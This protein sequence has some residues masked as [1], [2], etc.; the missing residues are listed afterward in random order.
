MVHYPSPS[1]C[2]QYRLE[3]GSTPNLSRRAGHWIQ[4]A[5][6]FLSWHR[7]FR[8][9]RKP[10]RAQRVVGPRI[11]FLSCT[12][13]A[14]PRRQHRLPVY[15]GTTLRGGSFQTATNWVPQTVPGSNDTAVFDLPNSYSV[16][17]GMAT[18][19][20][21]QIRDGGVIFTNANY[22][23]TAGGPQSAVRSC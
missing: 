19:E 23:A 8:V 6:Y 10:P 13:L 15:T 2:K 12:Q 9:C 17:V 18:T 7:V 11:S 14:P 3:A 20:Q 16:D 22:H 1:T 4:E 21:L 5:T